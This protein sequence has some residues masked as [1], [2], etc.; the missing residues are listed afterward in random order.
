MAVFWSFSDA[1][2]EHKFK[3]V[4]HIGL[5]PPLV[6]CDTRFPHGWYCPQ[7]SRRNWDPQPFFRF[8]TTDPIFFLLWPPLMI[9]ALK[10]SRHFHLVSGW[11]STQFS[12]TCSIIIPVGNIRGFHSPLNM[13]P[14]SHPC[15]QLGNQYNQFLYW[16]FM[17]FLQIVRRISCDES[18][19]TPVWKGV[20]LLVLYCLQV[21]TTAGS[22]VRTKGCSSTIIFLSCI[23]LPGSTKELHLLTSYT[24]TFLVIH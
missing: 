12:H 9:N 21:F 16:S 3:Q 19:A 8:T 13:A 4:H 15:I 5:Q 24:K 18:P 14:R 6:N 23:Y 11:Q 20:R 17:M 22:P 7:S 10:I 1:A 2:V